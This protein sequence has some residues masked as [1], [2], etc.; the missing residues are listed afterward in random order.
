MDPSGISLLLLF[1]ATSITS[2]LEPI[3]AMHPAPVTVSI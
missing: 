2:K 1:S 3:E